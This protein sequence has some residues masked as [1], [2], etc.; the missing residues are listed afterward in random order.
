M[1]G[2]APAFLAVC[3]VAAA[4][5]PAVTHAAQTLEP[6]SATVDADGAA[7]LMAQGIDIAESGFRRGEGDQ[8]V[9]FAATDA[10]VAKI[11]GDGI[12]VDDL[13][14]DKP[15]AKSAAAGDSPN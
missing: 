1:R 13:P 7:E 11:E 2:R 6:R 12:A 3:L 15:R 14:I 5:S 10:Q 9:Q 8:D 4:A